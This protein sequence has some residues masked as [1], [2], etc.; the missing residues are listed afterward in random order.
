MKK[1]I[2]LYLVVFSGL[3]ATAQVSRYLEKGQSGLGIKISA[4]TTYGV[5]GFS[6]QIGGSIK[7]IVDIEVSYTKNAYNEKR[8]D[9][10]LDNNANS[11]LYEGW[12]NVWL[13]RKE[14]IP[15]ILVDICLWGGYAYSGY[16][17]YRYM[18]P[19]TTIFQ[20][21]HEGQV[22]FEAG[23]TFKL[24]DTWWLQPGYFAYFA[25][26][27]E[28]WDNKTGLV[29]NNYTGVGSSIYVGLAK[30]IKKSTI[31]IQANQSFDSYQGSTN[32]YKISLGYV[33]GF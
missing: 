9:Y 13:F 16:K 8:L 10:L 22:G 6:A 31:Y 4:P 17:N 19:D 11:S 23:F 30:K 3:T 7:G 5:Q 25:F 24:T 20:S 28:R 33:L 29:K 32:A 2:I 14:I 1:L 15:A 27:Q 26:G 21:Y 18:E 12:I